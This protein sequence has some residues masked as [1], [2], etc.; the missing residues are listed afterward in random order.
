MFSMGSVVPEDKLPIHLRDAFV[1]AF[2]KIP[3]RVVWKWNYNKPPRLSPN[4]KLVK[5]FP[6]QDLLGK[7]KQS[8]SNI[9][10]TYLEIIQTYSDSKVFITLQDFIKQK[11]KP[12]QQ[13]TKF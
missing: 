2:S 7:C 11:L 3:Q 13:Q 9:L 4:V 8:D 6:Q 5:W 1:E 10:F 12:Q